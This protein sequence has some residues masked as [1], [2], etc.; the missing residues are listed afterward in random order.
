M[1]K[2]INQLDYPE[3]LYYV[4]YELGCEILEL[5]KTEELDDVCAYKY[6]DDIF[7]VGF[8]N[9]IEYVKESAEEDGEE[10]D[11]C[12]QD[13]SLTYNGAKQIVIASFTQQLVGLEN[14]IA[15]IKNKIIS[16]QKD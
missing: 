1:N 2:P 7:E 6:E 13:F 15:T 12:D 9:I 10:F 3:K 16:L 5:Q 8:D 14:D 4:C 11:E